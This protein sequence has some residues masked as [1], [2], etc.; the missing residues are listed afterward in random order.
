[1]LVIVEYGDVHD[2]FQFVFDIIAFGGRNVFQVDGREAG[3][4]R[5]YDGHKLVGIFF[6]DADRDRVHAAEAFEQDSLAFHNRHGCS[7][8]DVAQAQHAGAVGADT[9]H[10]AAAGVLKGHV[11]SFFDFFAGLGHAG[12]IGNR[13]IMP[14]IQGRLAA[15][16]HF[17]VILQVHCQGLLL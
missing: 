10:V 2:F 13:Q 12:G 1:M 5:F 3:F 9:G 4:Q 7:R 11:R 16:L 14:V 6:V 8:A 17:A 15:N